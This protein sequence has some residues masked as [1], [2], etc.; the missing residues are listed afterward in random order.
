MSAQ[1]PLPR[2]AELI[3][4][5][6]ELYVL[7]ATL[8]AL[9]S[10]DDDEGNPVRLPPHAPG[11][12][13]APAASETG[14]APD[15]VELMAAL[16][17][18]AVAEEADPDFELLPST[19]PSTYFGDDLDAGHFEWMRETLNDE[20]MPDTAVRLTRSNVYGVEWIYDVS[21]CR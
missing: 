16:P 19:K 15:A 9:P 18:L 20:M 17:Y 4:T 3:E 10:P 12:I 14:Y 13:N 1:V 11:T 21:S 6:Q 2:H 5:I 8:G 7:L